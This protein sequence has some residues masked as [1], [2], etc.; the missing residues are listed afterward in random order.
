MNAGAAYVPIDT[1]S[2]A[3]RIDF[4]LNDCG[5]THIVT[6]N[7]ETQTVKK[8]LEE[9]AKLA[10]VIGI[11]D[12]LSV[13]TISWKEVWRTS[14]KNLSVSLSEDDLAY[15]IY[16][17]GTTGNP[18]G[19]M[20]THRSGLNYARLSKDLYKVSAE[21]K[22]GNHS[23]LHFDISTFGYFTMPLAHGTTVIV[24]EAYKKFPAS[25]SQL[26]EKE[27]LT[28]WYSVP[29]ALSQ[30]LSRG[31]LEQRDLK[32]LR[33]VLFGGEPFSVKNLRKLMKILPRA[34]FSNVYGPAEV[35]QCTF[36][37][38]REF[39]ADYKTIPLGKAWDKTEIILVGENDSEVEKG[40]T[41]ELLVRTVTL[42]KGYWNRDDLTERALF[43][44]RD[45]A[46]EKAEVFYRTG[47]LACKNKNG[48]LVFKG[49]KDRQIKLRGY[50]IELDGIESVLTSHAKIDEAA[51][52]VFENETGEKAIA[53]SVVPKSGLEISGEEV[54]DYLG[55]Y[56]PRYV[57]L[58]KINISETLPRTAAGKLDHKELVRRAMG[59]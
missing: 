41:G 55:K 51:A 57:T 50:R 5:I 32:N 42:M 40:E 56:L 15:V 4:L 27:E 54:K 23:P 8:I 10:S 35:N 16:T 20:H 12:E 45:K 14:I 9:G 19:I 52:Y 36:Y 24:P 6:N 46:G 1:E 13:E 7:S 28:I 18:K 2:P 21:D 37:N 44:R 25:L 11:D 26:I 31:V 38:F 43:K 58:H 53:V 22:L 39:P 3:A 30:M 33:W 29:L 17:S 48:E 34:E 59:S 49:R 47:D